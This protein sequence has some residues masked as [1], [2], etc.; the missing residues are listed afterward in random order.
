MCFT[1]PSFAR[2]IEHAIYVV[3][4]AA[5]LVMLARRAHADFAVAD[6]IIRIANRLQGPD[7]TVDLA[8]AHIDVK[9]AAGLQLVS[10]LRH[11]E[12]AIKRVRDTAQGVRRASQ[13]ILDGNDALSSRNVNAA[14]NIAETVASVE[15]IASTIRRSTDNA[16]QANQLAGDASGVAIRGG[17]AVQRVVAT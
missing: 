7:G 9:G 2:V 4:E 8:A 14:S 11:I 13:E 10:A 6:E 17:E 3:A 5:V 12:A 1:E 16:H 15:H